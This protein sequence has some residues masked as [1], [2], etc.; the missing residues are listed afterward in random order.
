MKRIIF[1]VLSAVVLSLLPATYA[2][3]Q[4]KY[5]GDFHEG[6][7]RAMDANGNK[8]LINKKGKIV[9]ELPPDPPPT[10]SVDPN[11]MSW[12]RP[13]N[14]SEWER[15]GEGRY[16]KYIKW[17]AG[18][19]AYRNNYIIKH[20]Y[21]GGFTTYYVAFPGKTYETYA[22]AEAAAYFWTVHTE[23]RTRGQR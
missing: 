16:K 19:K 14:E 18:D 6:L 4:W 12:P 9:R 22:D 15:E 20:V 13:D 7:A 1:I 8:Y 23:T 10:P 3:A 17:N 2:S 11:S 5:K 21:S